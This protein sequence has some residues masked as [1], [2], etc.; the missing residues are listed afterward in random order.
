[1]D[2][3]ILFPKSGTMQT[4]IFMV[5]VLLIS[6]NSAISWQGYRRDACGRL[7]SR[8]IKMVTARPPERSSARLLEPAIIQ[9][10]L[11]QISQ[12]INLSAL[13]RTFILSL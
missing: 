13:I 11:I 12:N 8:A 2:G 5:Y 10:V 9:S 1:M 4:H 6:S 3:W 7:F